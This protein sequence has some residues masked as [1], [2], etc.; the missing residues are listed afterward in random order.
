MSLER[1]ARVGDGIG[2]RPD[3]SA[4]IGAY[5]GAG[6][7]A[8]AVAFAAASTAA[9][10]AGAA[11]VA[12]TFAVLVKGGAIALTGGTTILASVGTVLSGI[13]TGLFVGGTF[14]SHSRNI[15]GRIVTG[16]DTVFTGPHA[17]KA[18]LAH[19]RCRVNCHTAFVAQG[20]DSVFIEREHASRM[21]DKTSC[22]GTIDEG[23]ETAF[24]GGEP[25]TLAGVDVSTDRN[26]LAYNVLY[27]GTMFLGPIAGG[28]RAVLQGREALSKQQSLWRGTSTQGWHQSQGYAG[29]V[30]ANDLATAGLRFF[31]V[32]GGSSS[33]LVGN[34][35]N[36]ARKAAKSGRNATDSA[37]LG[38]RAFGSGARL[39]DW[40]ARGAS[41]LMGP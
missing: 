34:L 14:R 15:T 23:L 41:R 8:A 9:V 2:H 19:P 31:G 40:V 13:G 38:V 7:A 11:P 1:A 18:A 37:D 30:A 3:T 29:L 28:W 21:G 35:L 32:P 20:S 22:G 36:T 26:G 24:I 39:A 16:A 5:V 17:P 6:L 25:V 4:I 10:A 12:L 33:G 27:W